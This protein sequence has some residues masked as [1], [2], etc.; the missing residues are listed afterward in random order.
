[1][2]PPNAPSSSVEKLSDIKVSIKDKTVDSWHNE[3]QIVTT[4]MCATTGK[5]ITFLIFLFVQPGRIRMAER[6]L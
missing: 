1:V 6:E 3:G 2:F 5:E 4:F